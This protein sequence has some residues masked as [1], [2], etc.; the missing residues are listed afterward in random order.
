[1]AAADSQT[2]SDSD[3]YLSD[4]SDREPMVIED[5]FT[6][7]PH[8]NLTP[9]PR[10]ERPYG[11]IRIDHPE[12]EESKEDRDLHQYPLEQFLDNIARIPAM[13]MAV[14]PMEYERGED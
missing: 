9:F 7:D 10:E 2:Q 8:A 4:M 6:L 11:Y 5:N 1:M 3:S 13:A 12:M 14:D